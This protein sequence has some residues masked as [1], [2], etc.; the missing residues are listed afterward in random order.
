M[1]IDSFL[2]P[3][4]LG[5]MALAIITAPVGCFLIWNRMAFYG[6]AVAHGAM[7]GITLGILIGTGSGAGVLLTGGGMALLLLWLE[8][9]QFLAQDTL[10]GVLSHTA[11]AGG[12]VL[13]AANQSLSF[14]LHAVLLGDILALTEEYAI[15]TLVIVAGLCVIIFWLWRPLLLIVLQ[16]SLA[17]VD[18]LP[19][20]RIKILFLM[21]VA[22]TVAIGIQM[23]GVL[24]IAALLII[25]PATARVF[26][27]T[28]EKMVLLAILFSEIAMA[29][30][31]A[32]SLQLDLPTGPCI[33][34]SSSLLFTGSLILDTIIGRRRI[35]RY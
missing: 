3:A 30:G 13:L 2:L 33:V 26:A 17:M 10:L 19:V 5:G 6:D 4:L 16:E 14:N 15:R 23:V 28:P 7:P 8:R 22:A 35:L 12:L 21:T 25:P 29:G 31:I 32:C 11:L 1:I 18:G 34:L 24:L 20:L 27:S 9:R